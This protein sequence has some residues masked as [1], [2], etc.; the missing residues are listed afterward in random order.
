M[1][2]PASLPSAV[3]YKN[4]WNVFE[5]PAYK[6]CNRWWDTGQTFALFWD[7]VANKVNR[8]WEVYRIAI[9]WRDLHSKHICFVRIEEIYP[10][11]SVAMIP[12]SC[13]QPSTPLL[14]HLTFENWKPKNSAALSHELSLQMQDKIASETNLCGGQLHIDSTVTKIFSGSWFT[15]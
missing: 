11:L 8:D 2:V 14:L 12:M 1:V 13:L 4:V 10:P 9:Y 5:K 6:N 7:K 3:V 15:S